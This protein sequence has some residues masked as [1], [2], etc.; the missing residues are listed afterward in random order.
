MKM[1]DFNKV[2]ELNLNGT[3]S[4]SMVFGEAILR[5]EG[6]IINISS[7]ATYSAGV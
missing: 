4:P 1:A 5:G 6:S 2:M 7:M 3:V